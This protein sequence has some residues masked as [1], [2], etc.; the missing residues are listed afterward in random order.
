[1]VPTRLGSR[2][3]SWLTGNVDGRHSQACPR[4][5]PCSPRL[6]YCRC[7]PS[8]KWKRSGPDD[9]RIGNAGGKTIASTNSRCGNLGFKAW[10]LALLRYL[11]PGFRSSGPGGDAAAP[12]SQP[13]RYDSSHCCSRPVCH[14]CGTSGKTANPDAVG[15]DSFRTFLPFSRNCHRIAADGRNAGTGVLQPDPQ[16]RRSRHP[17]WMRIVVDQARGAASARSG[18]QSGWFVDRPLTSSV[19]L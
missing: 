5:R 3:G 8:G 15:M 7:L 17:P 19:R 12:A 16:R 4:L 18:C 6:L 13:L 11:Q 9:R 2:A 10:I 14:S 1:M